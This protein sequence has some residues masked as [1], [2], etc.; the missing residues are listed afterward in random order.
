[1]SI[2]S[3]TLDLVITLSYTAI[4]KSIRYAVQYLPELSS[5]RQLL[6]PLVSEVECPSSAEHHST[7]CPHWDSA[8]L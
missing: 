1:M 7:A 3:P 5:A 2:E 6:P 8:S 4:C